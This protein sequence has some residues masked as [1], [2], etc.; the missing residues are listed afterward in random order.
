VRFL[1]GVSMVMMLN[2]TAVPKPKTGKQ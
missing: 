2:D 1:G